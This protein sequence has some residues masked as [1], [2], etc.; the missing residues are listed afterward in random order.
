MTETYTMVG[1][2]PSWEVALWPVPVLLFYWA[3]RYATTRDAGF[4]WWQAGFAIC[5]LLASLADLPMEWI[6]GGFAFVAGLMML[7]LPIKPNVPRYFAVLLCVSMLADGAFSIA[8][9]LHGGNA[10]GSRRRSRITLTD[11]SM[12]FE[13]TGREPELVPRYG[14]KVVLHP[15]EKSWDEIRAHGLLFAN[16][17]RTS[18]GTSF[19][20]WIQG[21][22]L[23]WGPHGLE[24]GD[25][26]GIRVAKWVRSS[27]SRS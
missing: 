4:R 1:T 10:F 5:I 13:A 18:P 17:S 2:S 21:S 20:G 11:S 9:G 24:T 26:L 16:F 25:Q 19:F 23:Y 7:K 22:N 8:I 14:L 27:P 3:A 12:R 6:M 15:P